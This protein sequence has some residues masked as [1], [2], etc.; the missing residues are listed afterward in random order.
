MAAEITTID[1]LWNLPAPKESK[2]NPIT[3]SL[4]AVLSVI[5]L[6]LL[7]IVGARE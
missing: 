5:L 7:V 1:D 6:L 2:A 4:L 3:Y